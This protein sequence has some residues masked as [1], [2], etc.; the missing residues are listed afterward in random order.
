MTLTNPAGADQPVIIESL[1]FAS[2][3]NSFNQTNN[4]P[5]TL[6]AGSSCQIQSVLR[7]VQPAQYPTACC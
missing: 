6:A 2:A 4:C 3:T 1:V 5:A 7:Q